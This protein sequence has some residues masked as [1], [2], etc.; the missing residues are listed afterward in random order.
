[1]ENFGAAEDENLAAED[2]K[3]WNFLWNLGNFENFEKE[4]KKTILNFVGA[5]DWKFQDFL[6]N[7]GRF[8]ENFEKK[9]KKKRFNVGRWRGCKVQN[10]HSRNFKKKQY[11]FWKYYEK[12]I[13]I[14]I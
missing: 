3:F 8:F 2:G 5:A 14:E 9:K 4:Q 10:Q 7:L 11:K 1:M 12:S 6:W 13:W